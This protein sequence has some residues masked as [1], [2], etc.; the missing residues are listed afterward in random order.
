M[1][2]SLLHLDGSL[3]LTH[4]SNSDGG[5]LD[6]DSAMRVL[7]YVERIW[8]RPVTLHTVD[9]RGDPRRVSSK[10]NFAS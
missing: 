7:D 1:A 2:A 3:E 9:R 4:D 8:R 5:G 10:S 6:T